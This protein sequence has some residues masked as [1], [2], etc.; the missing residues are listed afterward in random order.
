MKPQNITI[1][2]GPE[3]MAALTRLQA[4]YAA[5]RNAYVI[6]LDSLCDQLVQEGL[7]ASEGAKAAMIRV[8][9]NYFD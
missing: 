5:A 1:Q 9:V 6:S 3:T 7:R 8:P 4:K 2:V